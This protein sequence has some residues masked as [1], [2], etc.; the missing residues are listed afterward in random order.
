M[1]FATLLAFGDLA[2]LYSIYAT[3]TGSNKVPSKA[4]EI[5][6]K[7]NSALTPNFDTQLKIPASQGAPIPRK[8]PT[9]V[10]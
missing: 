9:M 5:M 10:N 8:A 2:R 4:T 6:E 3:M 1:A 7:E